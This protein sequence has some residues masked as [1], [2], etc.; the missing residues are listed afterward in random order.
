MRTQPFSR[1]F[2]AQLV[3]I[4]ELVLVHH[5]VTRRREK[6]LLVQVLRWLM[7]TPFK[8][9][10]LPIDVSNRL[11]YGWGWVGPLFARY[12]DF[13]APGSSDSLLD[14]AKNLPKATCRR[15]LRSL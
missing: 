7:L 2:V 14:S 1:T 8:I 11:G 15:H 9:L 6:L 13:G 4:G 10:L 5:F 12:G 3:S